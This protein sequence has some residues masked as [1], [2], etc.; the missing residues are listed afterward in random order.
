MI[1]H[2]EAGTR[3][4]L[5]SPSLIDALCAMIAGECVT[6]VRHHR[7]VAVPGDDDAAL[8][9]MPAW[10]LGAYIGGVRLK[11]GTHLDL[12]GA[13]LAYQN[14]SDRQAI[15]PARVAN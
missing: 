2:D 14:H 13:I 3:N 11:P 5:P 12:A 8:P 10:Q 4:A 1:V 7:D 15:G 6:P 9:F